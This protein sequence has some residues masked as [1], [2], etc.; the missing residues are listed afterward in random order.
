MTAPSIAATTLYRPVGLKELE[1]IHKSG[2]RAFPPRLYWQPIFYPVTSREYAVRIAED[3]NTKD[4]ASDYMGFVLEFA[5]PQDY[6]A[7][8][9]VQMVGGRQA[10]ELWIPAERLEEFNAQIIG[11]IT[12]RDVF[13]GARA[14]VR[15][16]ALTLLPLGW[17]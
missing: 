14:P 4:E 2:M 15:T 10:Q 6:L 11:K 9:P 16:D 13:A 1:I 7:Q 8:F 3:W 5:L 17:V 12:V